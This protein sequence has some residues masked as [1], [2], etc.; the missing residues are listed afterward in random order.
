MQKSES[1]G[2]I[3]LVVLIAGALFTRAFP[4]GPISWTGS[5]AGLVLLVILLAYEGENQRTI[6]QSTGFAAVCGFCLF[7]AVNSLLPLLAAPQMQTA[8]YFPPL[9]WIAGAILFLIIDRSRQSVAPAPA[10]QTARTEAAQI[11]DS[12]T[13]SQ[14]AVPLPPNAIALPL[15]AGKPASIYLN[16]VGE[17]LACLRPVQAEHMGKDF[18]RIVEQVPEG[19]AW[20]FQPGQIVRCQKKNLSSGKALVAIEEA[21]RAR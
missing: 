19:E 16:L 9:V 8:V 15:G 13:P 1:N 14:D 18:Y 17:G 10:F 21:P 3:L 6:W 4:M 5:L 7:L 20:E 2:L 12:R 11:V